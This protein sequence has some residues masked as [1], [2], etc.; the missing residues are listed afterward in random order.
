MPDSTQK[1]SLA[2]VAE[3]IL[4]FPARRPWLALALSGLFT[5]ITIAGIFQLRANTSLSAL[6]PRGNPS[7]DAPEKLLRFAERFSQEV[8]KSP[9]ATQITEGVAYAPDPDFRKFIEQ[10]LVPSGLYYLDDEAFSRARQR[11]TADG[12]RQ[13]IRQ[14]ES[15]ISQPGPAAGAA[16]KQLLKDPLRLHE[17]VK[18]RFGSQRQFATWQGRDEFISPDGRA[19]L[20]R[21]TGTQSSSD[22]D[23]CEKM[24][25]TIPTIA[26]SANTDGLTLDYI[27]AYAAADY[28]HQAIRADSI[29]NV[30]ASVILLQVLFI[31]FYRRPIRQFLLEIVPVLLGIAIG[32]GV[33]GWVRPSIS[34]I[35]A[36]VGGILA[37]MGVDHSVMYLASYFRHLRDGCAPAEA[38]RRTAT[39]TVGALF[40]AWLTTIIGFVAIA[41]SS[42]RTLQEFAL[43]G[44]FGLLCAF[45]AIGCTHALG[46]APARQA[47]HP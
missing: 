20:I 38:V 26:T 34:P 29:E 42:V 11:L 1:S 40:V 12:I 27:G 44:S 18:E 15:L 4:T 9:H 25:K 46:Y 31:I 23:Y 16:A 3:R 37:G 10:V 43:L 30:F 35:A 2:R 36:V 13:Q 33:Y 45:A 8:A 17:F 14:N 6:F 22:L 24:M 28:S 5:A 32:F 7:A 41:F 21:I 47:R 39:T 19:I